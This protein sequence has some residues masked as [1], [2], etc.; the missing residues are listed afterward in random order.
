[1]QKKRFEYRNNLMKGQE[2]QFAQ[3]TLPN[4]GNINPAAVGNASGIQH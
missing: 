2:G 1:M 4:G 3:F